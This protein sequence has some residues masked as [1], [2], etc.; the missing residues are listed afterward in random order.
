MIR[1]LLGV[2]MAYRWWTKE[3]EQWLKDNYESLGLVKCAEHLNR[4]QTSIL[5]KVCN[6]GCANRRGG[7]RKPRILDKDGYLWVSEIGKQYAVHRKVM[8]EHIGRELRS[9]EIVHHI[10]GDTYDNRIENLEIVTRSEHQGACHKEDLN[11][12][13]DPNSGR[14]TSDLMIGAG[15]IWNHKS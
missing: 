7:K 13:R 12:R 14:F 6:L 10:N 8:E 2:Y 1:L 4:S 11:N 3:D 5:H 15:H 9:D